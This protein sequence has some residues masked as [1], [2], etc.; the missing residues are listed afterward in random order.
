MEEMPAPA[1][2][3][4]TSG[5][6]AKKHNPFAYFPGT[7][8]PN[9]VTAAQ[10]G[11]DESSGQLPAF[12]FYVPNLTDDGH[13]GTNEQV[14]NYLKNLIPPVLASNWYKE[15]GVIIITWDESEGEEK[16]PTVVVTGQGSGKTMTTAGNHYG[17]LATI[18]DLYG[19]P[20]L[21]NAVGATTLAPLLK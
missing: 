1:S 2:E 11:T 19:L 20:R 6:Y 4:C 10:F 5:G 18:Q 3:V 16:V 14:D 21:G 13:D 8:G 17:T 9:V 15:G 12:I 7:N